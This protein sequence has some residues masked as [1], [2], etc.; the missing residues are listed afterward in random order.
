MPQ[1]EQTIMM[2]A[3]W[4]ICVACCEVWLSLDPDDPCPRIFRWRDHDLDPQNCLGRRVV[5]PDQDACWAAQT[6]GGRAAVS[7]MMIAML[8]GQNG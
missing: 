4:C 3:K 2:A 5:H 1:V 8:D 6:I 7:A